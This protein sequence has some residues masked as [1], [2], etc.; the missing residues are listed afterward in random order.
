MTDVKFGTVNP[1]MYK[2]AEFDNM[3]VS[4][5]A[6]GTVLIEQDADDALKEIIK[7]EVISDLPMV[8]ADF[9]AK[10]VKCTEIPAMAAEMSKV[11]T[12]KLNERGRRC[13]VK[14]A[15]INMDEESKQALMQAQNEREYAKF[16]DARAVQE[17][18]EQM[19]AMQA[20]GVYAGSAV[21][22]NGAA[23]QPVQAQTGS[24]NRPKF[25]PNCGTP[26]GPTGKFCGNCG[27]PLGV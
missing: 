19:K 4:Y 14:L 18:A 24:I 9:N 20:A 25:C 3:T 26:V 6:F 13:T 16:A 11:L 2:A 1:I 21:A 15:A 5:R 17:Q 10:N 8:F 12:G 22:Y 7:R 23:T 27:S